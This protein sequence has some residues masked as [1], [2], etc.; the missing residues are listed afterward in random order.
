MVIL[1]VLIAMFIY[2]CIDGWQKYQKRDF[3]VL[4]KTI[5]GGQERH[6][7]DVTLCAHFYTEWDDFISAE[8]KTPTMTE[9]HQAFQDILEVGEW[10]EFILYSS[11][12]SNG[13]P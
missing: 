7:P 12:A 13:Y 11:K 2:T 1:I 8:N 6:F 10:G 5:S 9:K 4:S 3:F